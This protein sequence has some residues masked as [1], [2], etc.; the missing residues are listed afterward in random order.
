MCS[1]KG[2]T[3]IELLVVIAIIAILAA[4]LFPVFGRAKENG[5]RVSCVGNMRSISQA[6]NM[7]ADDYVGYIPMSPRDQ[8][9]SFAQQDRGFGSMWKY[10]KNN[11]VFLC[12]NAKDAN[13]PGADPLEPAYTTYYPEYANSV[14]SFKASYHFWPGLYSPKAQDQPDPRNPTIPARLDAD[15]RDPRNVLHNDFNPPL[16]YTTLQRCITLGGPLVDNFLHNYD[17]SQGR[18]G[19]LCLSLKGNV[20]FLPANGYPFAPD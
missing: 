19:V 15:I 17:A 8:G 16:D 3:L 20:R 18:K 4:I 6:L 13:K 14:H 7:Y 12:P 9:G 10:T 2:F 5:R 1:R 11:K